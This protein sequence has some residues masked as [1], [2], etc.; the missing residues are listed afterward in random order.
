MNQ[1]AHMITSAA[2]KVFIKYRE[3][4]LYLHQVLRELD[5][6]KVILFGSKATGSSDKYSDTD[7]AV[8]TRRDFITSGIYGAVDVVDYNHAPEKLKRLI[9]KEGIVLY[10]R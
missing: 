10:E 6:D 9:K 7:L 4:E 2:K 1:I 8:I 5:P 3:V